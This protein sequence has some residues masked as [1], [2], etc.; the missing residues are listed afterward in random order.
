MN[1]LNINK[2]WCKLKVNC[3]ETRTTLILTVRLCINLI[4]VENDYFIC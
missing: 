3:I 2:H 4:L 1:E